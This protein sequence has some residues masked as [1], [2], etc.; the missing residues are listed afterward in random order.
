[1]MVVKGF[2]VASAWSGQFCAPWVLTL[3]AVNRIFNRSENFVYNSLH[4]NYIQY[5]NILCS[6]LIQIPL[7]RKYKLYVFTWKMFS[8]FIELVQWWDYN[9]SCMRNNFLQS[10]RVSMSVCIPFVIYYSF[11]SNKKD[12]FSQQFQIY[13]S[14]E[15]IFLD[16]F[17]KNILILQFKL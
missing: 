10:S 17:H 13:M 14:L 1:M 11:Q 16:T 12:F 15:H 7:L 5:E 4:F 9:A 8:M 2:T 6:L 3:E